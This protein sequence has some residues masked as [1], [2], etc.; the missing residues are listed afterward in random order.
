MHTVDVKRAVVNGAAALN[1]CLRLFVVARSIFTET[2]CREDKRCRF[3]FCEFRVS[4]AS[5]SG[6]GSRPTV[7]AV[8]LASY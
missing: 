2:E 8:A 3:V 7:L 6:G 5:S 1:V 4:H